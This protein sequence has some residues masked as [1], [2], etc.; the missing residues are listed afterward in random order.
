[1]DL[2]L[3]MTEGSICHG[4]H[5]TLFCISR[6]RVVGRKDARDSADNRADSLIHSLLL[7]AAD[8]L[9]QGRTGLGVAEVL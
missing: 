4:A 9:G 1:M 7:G 6:R 5:F 3:V 8:D 2:A